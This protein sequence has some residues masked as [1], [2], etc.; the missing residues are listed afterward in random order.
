MADIEK[1]ARMAG[2]WWLLFILIG[3]V[4]YYEVGICR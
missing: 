4:S 3:P 2:L 1:T